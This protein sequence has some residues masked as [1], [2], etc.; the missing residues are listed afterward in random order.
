MQKIDQ[1][2]MIKLKQG[3]ITSKVGQLRMQLNIMEDPYINDKA[4]EIVQKDNYSKGN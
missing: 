4:M 3:E 1:I 2:R